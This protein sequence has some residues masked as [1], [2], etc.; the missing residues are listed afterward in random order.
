MQRSCPVSLK[1]IDATVARINAVFITLFVVL[2]LFTSYKLI[3]IILACDFCIRIFGWGK[4]S[5]ISNLS[6]ATKKMLHLKTRMS[7][8]APKKLAAFFGLTFLLLMIL[9]SFLNFTF[10]LYTTATILLIC[11]SLEVVFNYCV[12]CEIYHIYKKIPLKKV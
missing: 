7:D 6:V 9:L 1:H 5:P 11:T 2:F 8:P 12:G 3:L 10:A 4:Y